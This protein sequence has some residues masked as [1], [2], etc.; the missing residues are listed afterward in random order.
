M[1]HASKQKQSLDWQRILIG[2]IAIGLGMFAL[3][4]KFRMGLPDNTGDWMAGTFGKVAF[5]LTLVWLAWPQLQ[6]LKTLPGGG[7]AIASVMA[8]C[9]VLAT[10][11][12]LLLYLIPVL[13]GITILFV[14]IA[15]V[16]RNLLPPK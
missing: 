15:W 6:M 14:A 3:L 4:A 11:P 8:G 1:N 5:V 2:I 9:L 13:V 12:R 16:Q 7:V 10:R